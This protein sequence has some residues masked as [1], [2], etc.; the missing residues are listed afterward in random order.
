MPKI[1]GS[2]RGDSS[3][4]EFVLQPQPQLPGRS[5]KKVLLSIVFLMTLAGGI[6]LARGSVLMTVI[7]VPITV[8]VAFCLIA[9]IRRLHWSNSVLGIIS[10]ACVVLCNLF[11]PFL[12]KSIISFIIA[13]VGAII[14]LT[15]VR[16]M[17]SVYDAVTPTYN[18]VTVET[19]YTDENGRIQTV[20]NNYSNMTE[21]SAIDKA[22]MDFDSKMRQ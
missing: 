15:F 14:G 13:I 17:L 20:T 2:L 6:A 19:T 21:G 3:S 9:L 1:Q 10:I 7:I 4:K 16:G 11:M 8:I 18:N 12:A 22:R 5:A